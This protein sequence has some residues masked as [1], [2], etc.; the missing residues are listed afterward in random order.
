ML[1][2]LSL[3][4]PFSFSFSFKFQVV[5]DLAAQWCIPCNMIDPKFSALSNRYPDVT[6]VHADADKVHGWPDAK[7]DSIPAFKFFKGG[8]LVKH[9]S[10]MKRERGERRE[11][12]EKK[13]VAV[14]LMQRS[15]PASSRRASLLNISMV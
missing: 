4:L 9:F 7:V 3:S 10:G 15:S 5:V 8:K 12:R 2:I 1:Y 13:G 11:R 14:G 6:F